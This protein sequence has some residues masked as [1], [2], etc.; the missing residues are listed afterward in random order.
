MVKT[1]K[2]TQFVKLKDTWFKIKPQQ[3]IAKQLVP[4][5]RKHFLVTVVNLTFKKNFDIW[6][7]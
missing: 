2:V 7:E 3:Y 4:K 6:H 5:S 1:L